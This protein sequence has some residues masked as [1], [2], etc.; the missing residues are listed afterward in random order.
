MRTRAVHVTRKPVDIVD[1]LSLAKDTKYVV[2][3][4]CGQTTVH[5]AEVRKDPPYRHGPGH[6]IPYAKVWT[7][8]VRNRPIL[9]WCETES[10]LVVSKSP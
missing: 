8:T 3:N 4:V 2:Q 5:I 7:L 10:T 6:V 1:S 9:V